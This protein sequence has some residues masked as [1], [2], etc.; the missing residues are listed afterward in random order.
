MRGDVVFRIYG[1]HEGR[2]K[3]SFFGAFRT[4]AEAD[5]EIATLSAREMHGEN[6]AAKYHDR[7]FV[8][9]EHVVDTDFEIP[10]LPRPRDKFFVEVTKKPNAAREW[11][12]AVV[13]VFERRPDGEPSRVCGYERNHA[14]YQTFEPFRQGE[15]QLA[16]VSRDYTKTAVLDLA[17]G[18]IIAEE[19][20]ESPGS[21]FCPVGFY[22]PDWWDVNDSSIIPGSEYWS[23]DHEWPA[24]DWG[25][26]W[27]C[28]WGDDSSWKLQ[29]L[30]LRRV[31]EGVITRDDRFGYVE[32]ATGDY[33]TPCLQRDPPGAQGSR[34]PRFLQVVKSRGV[35]RV[36]IETYATFDLATGA[37]RGKLSG[38]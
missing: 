26:V 15:R 31:Q 8:V 10:G 37:P 21:G 13:D 19:M 24:S 27:G 7:G 18:E 34:A 3:D 28:E 25:F 4:Q 5:A 22:V 38:A 16:L 17:T 9:R 20:E 6:W 2:A 23:A 35:E 11:P 12:S 14:L 30:D 36:E 29:H 32:L 1:V 33:V